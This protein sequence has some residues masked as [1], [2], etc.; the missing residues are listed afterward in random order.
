VPRD[1]SIYFGLVVAFVAAVGACSTY[2]SEAPGGGGSDPGGGAATS[3][4]GRAGSSGKAGSFGLGGLGSG[5]C[6]SATDEC[7]EPDPGPEAFCSDGRR[8]PGEECDDGN[9]DSGDGCTATC[10]QV[11]GEFVCPTPGEPC[12]STQKC[13]DKKITSSETCDDGQVVPKDGDGCDATCQLESGWA[14]PITGMPCQAA[15]CGDGILV[16]NEQCED[17]NA[18]AADGDGCSS[19]CQVEDGFFCETVGAACE[20]TVCGDKKKQGNEPCDDGNQVV[21]DGCTPLCQVEPS[22][23]KTGG[24][25]T[26][27]CGD[28]L[29]LPSDDEDCD[30]GNTVD[31]D[32]CSATCTTEAGYD[33]K[34]VQGELPETLQLPLVFRDFVALPADGSTQPRHPDFNAGCRNLVQEGIVADTLDAQGKPANTGLCDLPASCTV[35]TVY[36]NT[37]DFCYQRDKCAGVD[38]TGCLGM[39]HKNHPL[40]SHPDEDPFTFWY[41]DTPGVNHTTVIPV[42]LFKNNANVYSYGPA[43]GLYPIDMFGWVS[44]GAEATFETHNYGFTTEIRQWFQ[45]AGGETLTFSGDDDVW[46]YV[47]GKLALDLGGKHGQTT[48]TLVLNANGSAT[49]AACTTKTRPLGIIVGNVYEIAL[50]HAERQT[51][52]SNFNLNLAG[53][54]RAKSECA[55]VCGDGVITGIE[56]CDDGALN[57]P[58]GYNGCTTQCKRGPYCGDGH[59]DMPDEDCD[60][61]VNLSQYGG[62]APGCKAGPFCGDGVVQSQFEECDDSKLD[63][64]YGGCAKNCV[65]GPRCGD[66]V[67]QTNAGET[68]DDGNRKNLD[69]CSATCKLEDVK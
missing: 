21:G 53:F 68:C 9:V 62:C 29:I 42:T 40:A 33:C 63:G 8:D 17:D 6:D 47:N 67:V 28:G 24:A 19:A 54:A 4:G 56:E 16:G 69:G 59:A 2:S 20:R 5:G 35:N 13:G 60:D 23:P 43:A 26:S 30:D 41:R 65:L 3:G 37:G 49:C 44:S 55:P 46:V 25:C 66:E 38:P 58:G 34:P 51:A 15:V 18:V 45:F 10:A 52:A 50:F 14:C 27:R 64:S 12:V 7:D 1:G 39:T 11:E 32:G 48:R 57:G 36:V 61:S 22:C 31:G